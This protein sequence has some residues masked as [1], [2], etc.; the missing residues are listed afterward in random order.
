MAE[1]LGI[2]EKKIYYLAKTGKIP[3]TRVT[4]KWTFPK[5]L[6]DRWIEED[7]GGRVRNGRDT[8][9]TFI[10]AAGSDDPS[11]G[12][13]RDL[14]TSR[15]RPASLFWATVGSTA[16]LE[17]IRDRVADLALAHL[18]DAA[19]GEYN[20]PYLQRVLPS[21]AAV[22]PLFHRELGLLAR[23]GNP[24]G[25]RTIADLAR[26]GVR[27]INRQEGSGTRL[28]L[29]QELGHLGISRNGSMDMR[30]LLPRTWSWE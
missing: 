2:N 30:R 16:G 1:Y 27:I 17:A 9:R 7:A 6:I 15:M 28:Y 11:L 25:L 5:G 22:I 21:G 8:G 13:L 23:P 10:L 4:G 29:D 26:P 12:V 20:L 24:L 18:L 3:C 14:Y 19:T